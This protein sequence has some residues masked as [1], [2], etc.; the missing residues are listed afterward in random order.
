MTTQNCISDT[1]KYFIK[2]D[3]GRISLY[4]YYGDSVKTAGEAS[5]MLSFSNK[6]RTNEV[7]KYLL[8]EVDSR[9]LDIPWAR[10]GMR[11]LDDSTKPDDL[12]KTSHSY[13]EWVKNEL[14][15]HIRDLIFNGE[16]ERIGIFNMDQIHFIMMQN[17]KSKIVNGRIEEILLWLSSLSNFLKNNDWEIDCDYPVPS[18]NSLTGR[19]ETILYL[20]R[21]R[22][23]DFHIRKDRLFLIG[24]TYD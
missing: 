8:D 14:F 2:D 17:R 6:C 22:L 20:G 16:I 18:V 1:G 13:S 10:T 11:Y 7:Y 21:H 3:S 15:S 9:L 24:F 4:E 23:R 5:K 12:T 19:I